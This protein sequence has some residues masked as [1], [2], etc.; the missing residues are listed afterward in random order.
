MHK[1]YNELYNNYNNLH[2]ENIRLGL[3]NKENLNKEKKRIWRK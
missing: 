2:I 3:K 1:A